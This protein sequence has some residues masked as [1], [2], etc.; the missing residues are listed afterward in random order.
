MGATASFIFCLLVVPLTD[1]QMFPSIQLPEESLQKLFEKEL[2]LTDLDSELPG[3]QDAVADSPPTV[4]TPL[5]TVGY[6]GT[7]IIRT[8]TI[9]KPLY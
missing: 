2:V 3:Q 8:F 9:R 5:G 6:C 1:A 7:S 4:H